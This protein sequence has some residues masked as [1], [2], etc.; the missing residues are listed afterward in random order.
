MRRRGR[1]GEKSKEKVETEGV[2]RKNKRKDGRRRNREV[3]K[4]GQRRGRRKGED[5]RER[6]EKV[7]AAL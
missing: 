5:M 2:M 6:K 1:E 3:E 7:M 4:R